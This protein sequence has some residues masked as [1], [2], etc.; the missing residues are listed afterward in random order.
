MSTLLTL[1]RPKRLTSKSQSQSR[2]NQRPPLVCTWSSVPVTSSG[3]SPFPRDS[4]SA[5]ATTAG[6]WFLFG[7]Y[8]QRHKRNDLF[9]FSTQDFSTT[10]LQTSGEVP[11]PRV[12]PTAVLIGTTLLIWGGRSGYGNENVL[13]EREDDSLYLL[14]LGT[15]DLL[16]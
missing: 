9:V 7:G 1:L 8:A 4:F 14:N 13:N 16:M 11:S 15:S 12:G 3:P 2:E 10:L 5:T 6:E